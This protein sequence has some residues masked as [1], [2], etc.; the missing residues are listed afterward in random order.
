VWLRAGAL[1]Y[2]STLQRSAASELV[3]CA[4]AGVRFSARTFGYRTRRWGIG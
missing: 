1:F 3:L 2:R 4:S